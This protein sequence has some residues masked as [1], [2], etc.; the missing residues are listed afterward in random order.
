L[1]SSLV[2]KKKNSEA[3]RAERERKTQESADAEAAPPPPTP[4]SAWIGK[5]KTDYAACSAGGPQLD[6]QW[7]SLHFT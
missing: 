3:E 1:I 6:V 2:R 5:I 7:L 4:T